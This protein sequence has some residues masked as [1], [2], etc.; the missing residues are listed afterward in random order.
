LGLDGKW[1]RRLGVV[2]IYRDVTNGINL[3]WSC[4][5]SESYEA[6]RKDLDG[7]YP[8]VENNSPDGIISDWKN[9]IVASIGA[10]FSDAVYQRC[11]SHLKR[12]SC[13]L[14]PLRSPYTATQELRQVALE[15]MYIYDPSDF[16]DWT[17]K[18]NN[19]T[20][21]YSLFLKEKTIGINTKKK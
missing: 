1:L 21:K 9:S 14:L 2:M 11:L 16:Y 18:L 7:L 13:R 8:V 3:Y 17:T 10:Y 12:Q 5:P 20:E 4:H 19:W 6:I 15:I